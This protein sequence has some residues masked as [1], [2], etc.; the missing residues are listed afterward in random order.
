[1]SPW[2]LQS[3]ER[4]Q[5]R[6][7]TSSPQDL[8]RLRDVLAALLRNAPQGPQHSRSLA[9]APR[10]GV[11][12]CGAGDGVESAE[13]ASDAGDITDPLKLEEKFAQ[14]QASEPVEIDGR[15][16]TTAAL[17]PAGAWSG[18]VLI[19]CSRFLTADIL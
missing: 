4:A 11:A 5:K 19:V 14:L 17:A 18:H 2:M 16:T 15:N 12:A 6:V 10:T 9:P 3:G 7:H 1:M 8:Q 13:R